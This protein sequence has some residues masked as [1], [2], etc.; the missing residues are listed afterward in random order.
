MQW[1]FFQNNDHHRSAISKDSL[2]GF[3]YIN[4]M[5]GCI[6]YFKEEGTVHKYFVKNNTLK[7]SKMIRITALWSYNCTSS[8]GGS[9]TDRQGRH[10]QKQ[11]NIQRARAPALI[12]QE[13]HKY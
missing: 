9:K 3:S 10:K 12:R 6:I 7:T 4:V 2:G 8:R 11:I 5:F 13:A 1:H